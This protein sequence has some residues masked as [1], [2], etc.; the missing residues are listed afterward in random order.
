MKQKEYK[1][2][3]RRKGMIYNEIFETIVT[4]TS[5]QQAKLL[6]RQDLSKE[7]TIIKVSLNK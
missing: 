5:L 1:V 2:N 3:Y 7:Y 6:A 4:A